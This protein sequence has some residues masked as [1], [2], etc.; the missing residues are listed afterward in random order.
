MRGSWNQ[1][2]L[3]SRGLGCDW[4]AQRRDLEVTRQLTLTRNSNPNTNPN[5]NPNLNP[6]VDVTIWAWHH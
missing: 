3:I 5:P 1:S 6:K 2:L 4:M